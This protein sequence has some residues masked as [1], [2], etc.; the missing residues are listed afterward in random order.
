MFLLECDGDGQFA[1]ILCKTGSLRGV[2]VLAV[3]RERDIRFLGGG[4]SHHNRQKIY[5][6]TSSRWERSIY[7]GTPSSRC[8]GRS[9]SLWLLQ[10]L[11]STR[12][13]PITFVVHCTA[14]LPVLIWSRPVGPVG[15]HGSPQCVFEASTQ[16]DFTQS[17][18]ALIPQCCGGSKELA[19]GEARTTCAPVWNGCQ[20]FL[21]K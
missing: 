16:A 15:A 12:Q 13:Q 9:Q 10:L 11:W 8:Q 5:A 4:I 19:Y 6:F 21:L 2:L 20:V 1:I 7:R 14:P 17:N 3:K 18:W